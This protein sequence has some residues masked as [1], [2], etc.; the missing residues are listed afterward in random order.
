MHARTHARTH[1]SKHIRSEERIK[2]EGERKRRSEEEGREF[3]AEKGPSMYL[4][5]IQRCVAEFVVR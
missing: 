3:Q 1:A 4:L 2:R 5:L